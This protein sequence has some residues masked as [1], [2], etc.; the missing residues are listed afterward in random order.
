MV[1][2]PRSL[3]YPQ[4]QKVAVYHVGFRQPTSRPS[5][6]VASS[7]QLWRLQAISSEKTLQ[8]ENDFQVDEICRTRV[9]RASDFFAASMTRGSV[10][11]LVRL[12]QLRCTTAVNAALAA[13]AAAGQWLLVLK[14]WRDMRWLGS[15][16]LESQFVELSTS[17][18]QLSSRCLCPQAI[19]PN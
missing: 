5:F 14:L 6:H 1:W 8:T 10:G 16:C 12:A 9:T 2:V 17:L 4:H 7:I 18:V 13:L 3:E 11:E 15:G 19:F